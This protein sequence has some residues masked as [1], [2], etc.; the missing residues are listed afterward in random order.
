MK[1]Y[2]FIYNVTMNGCTGTVEEIATVSE[3]II[4]MVN[5][6]AE[7]NEMVNII[8]I[9]ELPEVVATV[10][11]EPTSKSGFFAGLLGLIGK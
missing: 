10:V 4:E 3:E 1:T 6:L 2:K 5:N 11:E 9:E 8:S 7:D